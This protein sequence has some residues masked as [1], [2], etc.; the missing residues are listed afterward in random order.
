MW[1]KYVVTLVQGPKETCLS[2]AMETK[3][4]RRSFDLWTLGLM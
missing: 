2:G 4:G 1:F 3:V